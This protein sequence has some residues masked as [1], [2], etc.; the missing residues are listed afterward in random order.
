MKCGNGFPSCG[1]NL[2]KVYIGLLNL[3]HNKAISIAT[4]PFIISICKF[5][6][7]NPMSVRKACRCE[8]KQHKGYKW[9]YL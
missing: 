2:Q 8:L 9:R 7:Y 1:G 5:R 4:V 6:A 3:L